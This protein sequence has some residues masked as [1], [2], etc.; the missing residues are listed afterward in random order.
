MAKELETGFVAK[1]VHFNGVPYRYAV[2]V[3]P[4]YDENQCWPVVL[5]LH[6]KGECGDDGVFHTTVGL[7]KAIRKNP[8][9][10]PALVVMPQMPVDHRWEGPMLDLALATLTET[11]HEYNGDPERVVLTG[12]SLGGYGTWA[13]GALAPKQFCALVPICGGGQPADAERL[14][15]VPIWCLH[16]DADPVVPVERSREMVA[17]VQ[18]AGGQIRYSELP[19]VTHNSWDPAYSDQEVIAWMLSQ[20]R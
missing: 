10:F 2:W 18:R 15:R 16:G 8:E 4:E 14:A 9:R 19:G 17:A 1:V 5:F 13:L 12:L 6:G 7:G 3:P 11:M 20:R